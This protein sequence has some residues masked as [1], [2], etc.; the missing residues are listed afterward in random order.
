MIMPA[1][2]PRVS[3][4]SRNNPIFSKSALSRCDYVGS[5]MGVSELRAVSEARRRCPVSSQS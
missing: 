5:T 2:I 3:Y 1:E 4:G